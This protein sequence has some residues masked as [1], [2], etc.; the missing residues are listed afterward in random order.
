MD[1]LPLLQ[2]DKEVR[3]HRQ[4]FQEALKVHGITVKYYP[5]LREN[6]QD[7][8]DFYSDYTE[9]E[10]AYQDP[11]NIR[12]LFQNFP[13]PKTLRSLGWYIED[14]ELP[15]M[16]YIP[17]EYLAEGQDKE[18]NPI[19]KSLIPIVDDKIILIENTTDYQDTRSERAYIVKSLR[20]QGYPNTIYHLA[21]LVPY[22]ESKDEEYNIT[23]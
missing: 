23:V 4:Q 1:R 12:I 2:S 10:L 20:S 21:K 9:H 18:G 3:Y 22:Y 5:I 8:Y 7:S 17:T 14:E 15:Y 16:A 13:N 19:T 11:I 6:T